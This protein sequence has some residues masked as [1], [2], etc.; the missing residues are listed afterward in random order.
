M[1]TWSQNFRNTVIN[2]IN[3]EFGLNYTNYRF[4]KRSNFETFEEYS[5][6]NAINRLITL[7]KELERMK[8]FKKLSNEQLTAMVDKWQSKE[9]FQI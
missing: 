6:T 5:E 2:L 1:L 8:D 3:K 9:N 7:G 4:D